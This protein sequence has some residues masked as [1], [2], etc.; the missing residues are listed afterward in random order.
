MRPSLLLVLSALLLACSSEEPPSPSPGA[1][2]GQGGASGGQAGQ[3]GQ[4]GQG[5]TSAGAAGTSAGGAGAGAAGEDQQ[6]DLRQDYCDPLANLLC[7]RGATCGCGA[8]FPGGELENA[9]C[10]E[11]QSAKCMEAYGFLQEAVQKGQA[12][13]DRSRARSCIDALA[14][15][16][17]GC[18]RLRPALEDAGCDPWFGGAEKQGDPCAF[19]LCAGGLGV[20]QDGVCQALSGAGAPCQGPTCA[21]GLI[22]LGGT[23][24]APAA[25]GGPCED[26]AGCAAGLL[27]AGGSCK[28]PSPAGAPCTTTEE[29]AAGLRCPEGVCSNPEGACKSTADCGQ[30]SL[31]AASRS[32][33]APGAP[34]EPC[35]N[36]EDCGAGAWCSDGIC[37][38]SAGPGQPCDEGVHCG[39]GLACAMDT[40]L[41]QALPG[42][43]APCALG[44]FGPVLCAEGLGCLDGVC[45]P[46]PGEGKPCA[47]ENRCTTADLDGDGKGGDLGCDFTAE[48]SFCN[49]RRGAGAPCQN[50]AIC[51]DQ[52]HCD[53]KTGTCAAILPPGSPCSAGNECGPEGTCQ[54]SSGGTFAC[55]PRPG[56]GAY[57][58]FECQP[59]LRCKQDPAK[60]L[61]LPGACAQL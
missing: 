18:E 48:G 12:F 43:G 46:L 2:G 33:G 11:A 31:C 9:A 38:S 25:Q 42:A 5:G 44:L 27:C 22:C 40:G 39:I 32:C 35:E 55:A 24:K 16:A 21:A 37:A 8:L 34:G 26:V 30:G 56:A 17:G 45:G 36:T 53:G 51:Q 41:C 47:M 13:V 19:P 3:A 50:D 6:G 49:P 1:P 23:C 54:P 52:L 28:T 7:E 20:C 10:V 61:C 60:A 4:A 14:A 59:G 57:C 15:S 58:L 29:C